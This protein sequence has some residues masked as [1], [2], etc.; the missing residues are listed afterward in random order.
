MG[1]IVFGRRGNARVFAT[2]HGRDDDSGQ[3]YFVRR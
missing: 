2:G 1:L 3:G